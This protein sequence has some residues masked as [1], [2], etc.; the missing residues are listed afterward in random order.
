MGEV[1]KAP[2]L[3]NRVQKPAKTLSS[4]CFDYIPK[5]NTQEQVQEFD[6]NLIN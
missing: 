2:C 3:T 5:I 6:L 1:I 4:E